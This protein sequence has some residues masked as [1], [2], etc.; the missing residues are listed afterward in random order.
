MFVA[1]LRII[2]ERYAVVATGLVLLGIALMFIA[3]VGEVLGWWK[4][5]GLLVGLVGL[6][7][8]VGGLL[9]AILYSSSKGEVR[10]VRRAVTEVG[11]GVGRVEEGVG[12]VEQGVARVERAV[13]RVGEKVG[14]GNRRIIELLTQIRDRLGRSP[15]EPSP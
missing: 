2:V 5:F 12:R 11:A 1:D 15:G 4:D 14:E 13:E 8:A 3:G 10:A 7:A 6:A 9:V